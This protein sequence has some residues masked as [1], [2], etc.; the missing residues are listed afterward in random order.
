MPYA[1]SQGVRVHYEVEGVGPPLVLQHGFTDTIE[2]WRHL[3][4]VKAL[5]NDFQISL[6]DARGHGQGFLRSDLVLPNVKAFLSKWVSRGS[7]LWVVSSF[8][9]RLPWS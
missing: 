8:S 2:R 5:N 6:A 7:S 3:G 1:H 4:Y 9:S